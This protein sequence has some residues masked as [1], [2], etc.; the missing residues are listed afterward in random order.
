[1]GLAQIRSNAFFIDIG[2]DDTYE[3]GAKTPGLGEAT[4][5]ADYL[6]PSRYYTYNSYVTSF[7]GFI[8]IGGNDEYVSFT[9]STRTPHAVARNNARLQQPAPNDSTYGA[10]NFGVGIVSQLGCLDRIQIAI[11]TIDRRHNNVYTHIEHCL[12]FF[13]AI[14]RV[15]YVPYFDVAHI[16]NHT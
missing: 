16:Q 10:N 2:G 15:A 6:T 9:D 7:G 11:G 8:D 1:M 13:R 14:S 12:P 3:L 5:R 4:W